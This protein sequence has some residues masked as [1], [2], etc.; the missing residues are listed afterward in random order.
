ML[1]NRQ[2]FDHLIYVK[3]FKE[4]LNLSNGYEQSPLS[5]RS[6][7]SCYFLCFL[8][9]MTRKNGQMISRG[10]NREENAEGLAVLWRIEDTP[11][12]YPS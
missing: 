2:F 10:E 3:D 1:T 5:T 12:F 8:E 6:S 4:I 11:S 9:A 7:T